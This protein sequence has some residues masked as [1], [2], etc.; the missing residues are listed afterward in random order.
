M[1]AMDSHRAA[2]VVGRRLARMSAGTALAGAALF[3]SWAPASASAIH[4]NP[5]GHVIDIGPAPTALPANCPFPNNDAS[6]LVVSG[7][8]VK[9]DTTNKNGDWGGLTFEGD[10]IFQEAPYSGFDPVTGNPIDTGPA[11]QYYEGHLTYWEGGGNNAT[12][13]NEGGSTLNF[14]GTGPL[15]TLDVHVNGHGTINDNGTPTSNVFNLNASCS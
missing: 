15:G 5:T 12:G 4:P 10:A 8:V 11:V 14:H 9:H 6:F 7:N 3:A 13:Q 1:T 2:G